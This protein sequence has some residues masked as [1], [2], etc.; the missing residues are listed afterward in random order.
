L[1]LV[2]FTADALENVRGL[3]KHVRNCLRKEIRE[4]VAQDPY[5]CSRELREPLQGFRTFLYQNYRVIF[6]VYED[7]KAIGIAGVGRRDATSQA[8]VYKK[9]QTLALE[10]KLAERILATLQGFSE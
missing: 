5:G 9:L 3:P 4:K 1:Y 10:G 2:K 6:K 7:V 8:D